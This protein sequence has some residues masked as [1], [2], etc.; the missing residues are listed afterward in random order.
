MP[1]WLWIQKQD[2]G[3]AQRYGQAMAYDSEHKLV[4]LFG[5]K[6]ST[7]YIVMIPGRG[8]DK[9][10][11]RWPT[12]VQIRVSYTRMAFDSARQRTVLFGGN[13]SQHLKND[14]WEWD[15]GVWTQVAD[16]GPSSRCAHG[17]TFDSR[18]SAG[19]AVWRL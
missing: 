10:G 14:T 16:T 11:P 2:I 4:V 3:P 12:W 9:Y 1:Q 7:T 18:A 5:G 13:D 19:C 15:G 6:R 17:I 8:T